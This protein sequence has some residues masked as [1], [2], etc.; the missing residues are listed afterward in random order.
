[1][2]SKIFYDLHTHTTY[3]HGKGSIMDN[4]RAAADA[5]LETL[6]IAD[7][8]PGHM[9]YGIDMNLLDNMRREID[10]ARKEFPQLEILL[11]VEANI[12]N[13]SGALDVSREDQELFDFIIAGYHYGYF[14]ERFFHGL[15]T[16]VKGWLHDHGLRSGA[17][18]KQQN[19]EVVIAA[20]ESN[21]IKILTH[22]GDKMAVDIEAIART[23]ERRG[24]FLEIN[25]HHNHL[26]VDEIKLIKEYDV[27][28]VLSSDAHRPE[29]VGRVEA[30]LQ[31]VYDAELDLS[32]VVNYRG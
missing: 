6:G 16:C 23:C 5:G 32:R 12:V 30:S 11:G 24:T 4:A 20:L 29:N 25:N 9:N 17:G 18:T 15:N 14:G 22:P 27:S 13:F 7:H 28:F 1:M 19:T 2:Q 21:D 26:T 31:R 10:A 8:G 3:S